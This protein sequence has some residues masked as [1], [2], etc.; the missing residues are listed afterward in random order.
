LIMIMNFFE[1]VMNVVYGLAV[2]LQVLFGMSFLSFFVIDIWMSYKDPR[3][4]RGIIEDE[5]REY[6][7]D[8]WNGSTWYK[9]EVMIAYNVLLTLLFTG[10]CF[11]TPFPSYVQTLFMTLW[12]YMALT[13]FDTVYIPIWK[14]YK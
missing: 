8:F 5:K 1:V 11:L 10:L 13:K 12:F 7:I 14:A 2:A 3:T 9:K 4:L 6:L